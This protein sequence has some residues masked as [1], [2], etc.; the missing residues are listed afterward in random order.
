MPRNFFDNFD[1]TQKISKENKDKLKEFF[2]KFFSRDKTESYFNFRIRPKPA[3][4]IPKV[5]QL[6]QKIK[7]K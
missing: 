2:P 6:K 1:T 4:Y 3:F 5:L 7:K